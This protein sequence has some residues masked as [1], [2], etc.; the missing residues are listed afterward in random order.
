MRDLYLKWNI[1]TCCFGIF[2][3]VKDLN[4]CILHSVFEMMIEIGWALP[5]V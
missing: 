4:T 5:V 1:G 2:T 3:S